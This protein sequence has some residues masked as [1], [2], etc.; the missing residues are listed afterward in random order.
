MSVIVWAT[1]GAALAG[2]SSSGDRAVVV[3]FPDGALVALIDGLGHGYEACE[4]AL[5]AERVLLAAPYEPVTVLVQRCHE[6]LRGT[7]GAVMSLASFDAK[8]GA[9]SWL[10]VGNVE[11]LLVRANGEAR[12]AVA[13]RGGTV[14]YTLPPLSPRTL[15]VYPGD[16]LAFASD[17][18]RHGFHDEIIPPRSPQE[19]ADQVIARWSKGTDDAC[20]VVAR[21]V[22]ARD[23]TKLEGEDEIASE[24]GVGTVGR[25]HE[26]L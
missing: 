2:E 17:G 1:A 18:I 7:R 8:S 25:I 12:D 6:A 4:A 15:L 19:I 9:M 16:T 20:V 14:G 21:Y 22:G 11:G 5:E 23:D 24:L 26:W 3:P 13:M 10:A